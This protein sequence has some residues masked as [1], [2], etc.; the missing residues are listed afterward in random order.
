MCE[1]CEENKSLYYNPKTRQRS[2][3]RESKLLGPS[4]LDTAC[5]EVYIELD[6]SITINFIGVVYD[7]F[8]GEYIPDDSSDINFKINYCPMCGKKLDS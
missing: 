6:G 3:E 7:K 1:Y 5:K 2:F 4:T 8:Y